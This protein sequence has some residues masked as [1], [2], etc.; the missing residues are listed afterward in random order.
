[1]FRSVLVHTQNNLQKSNRPT[2][3]L[4]GKSVICPMLFL[5]FTQF[6]QY[7][8]FVHTSHETNHLHFVYFIYFVCVAV[9]QLGM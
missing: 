1:M 6:T 3:K 5:G 9:K 8:K 7:I 4:D 2:I